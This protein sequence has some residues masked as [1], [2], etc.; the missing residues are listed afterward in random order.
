M[1][2][3]YDATE[4]QV[5]RVLTRAGFREYEVR[6]QGLTASFLLSEGKGVSV[7]LNFDAG[8]A[9]RRSVFASYLHALVME[10]FHAD[11]RGH[12][13]YVHGRPEGVRHG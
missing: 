12:Y 9:E 3:P 8:S 10:G 13:L 11:Y 1:S 5:R 2:E 6:D 4:N 7:S